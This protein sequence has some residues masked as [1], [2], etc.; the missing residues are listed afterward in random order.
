MYQLD[1][2][3]RD[4]FAGQLAE[5]FPEIERTQ[6]KKEAREI[7]DMFEG[8]DINVLG[9]LYR[10]SEKGRFSEFTEKLRS[11]YE[12]HSKNISP[13]HRKLI[14]ENRFSKRDLEYFL[15]RVSTKQINRNLPKKLLELMDKP[16]AMEEELFFHECS[17]SLKP[18]LS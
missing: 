10:A 5:L 16:K 4:E 11:Y 14:E 9:I 6:V 8:Q 3:K 17:D 12:T 18:F 15:F 13:Y 1:E 2:T 7:S